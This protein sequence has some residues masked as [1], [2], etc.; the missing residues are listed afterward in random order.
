MPHIKLI[1]FDS[2]LLPKPVIPPFFKF[3]VSRVLQTFPEA[4][5]AA[6]CPFLVFNNASWG[7]ATDS[8]SLLN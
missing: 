6:N 8:K 1:N 5:N 3:F 2:C 4:N 7:F